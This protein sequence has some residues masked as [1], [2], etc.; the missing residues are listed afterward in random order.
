MRRGNGIALQSETGATPRW[1]APALL[2]LLCILLPRS[3]AYAELVG[4]GGPV[5]AV[6]VS[7]DGETV[8]T[9]GFDYSVIHWDLTAEKA[10]TLM[11]GH[12]AAVGDVAFVRQTGLAVS[13]GN[14]GNVYLWQIGAAD[15]LRVLHRHDGNVSAVA[16]SPDGNLIA[17]AGFDGMVRI[18]PLAGDAA[19]MVLKGHAGPVNAVL[20][21]D[22]GDRLLS[23]GYDG[24]I[25][26]WTPATQAM[27]LFAEIGL[28]VNRLSLSPDGKTLV[29]AGTDEAVRLFDT[30]SREE[31][32][33]MLGHEAPVLSIAITPDGERFATG[34]ARG[35]IVFWSL[36]D[37]RPLKTLRGHK[38]PVWSVAFTP[39]GSQLLSA[40]R[41]GRVIRWDLETGAQIGA[42]DA[43]DEEPYV[44][45]GDALAARGAKLFG[46]C[47]VCHTLTP[48]GGHRAGPTLYG[49]FGRRVGTVAGYPYSKALLES[50]IVWDEQTI[51]A[52]FEKGPQHVVPGTKM[53]LQR[54]RSSEDRRALLHF[55]RQALAFAERQA[56]QT[57]GE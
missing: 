43:T 35:Q 4:H 56:G 13:G 52:L 48:D 53:P 1:L 31:R 12:D 2:A 45:P 32:R 15:P 16:V 37:G 24:T 46:T 55:L 34:G 38:G 19:P 3:P 36:A 26:L 42:G 57:K 28:P 10:R 18:S 20:F 27:E 25:R 50:D 41:D 44:P 29:V 33:F 23:A 14:D 51:G 5:H 17:S 54:L 22:A 39:G 9:A 8:L 49:V 7:D 11:Y 6:A 21:T 40:G 47:A 30:E